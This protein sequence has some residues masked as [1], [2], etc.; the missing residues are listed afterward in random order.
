ML[1]AS[2]E[3]PDK[4]S[5]A[6]EG[7]CGVQ[8]AGLSLVFVHMQ[9]WWCECFLKAAL[10]LQ[11]RAQKWESEI[12]WEGGCSYSTCIFTVCVCALLRT[13]LV[14]RS[15]RMYKVP[16]MLWSPLYL[17]RHQPGRYDVRNIFTLNLFQLPFL[18][19][20]FF[21]LLASLSMSFHFYSD[22]MRN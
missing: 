22:L 14:W 8:S 6:E 20:F 12:E 1:L 3:G 4:I 2:F 5:S 18:N 21:F 11:E 7:H 10:F 15:R 13:H 17:P 16:F 19:L 9:Q